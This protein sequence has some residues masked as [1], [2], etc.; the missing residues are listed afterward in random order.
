M[1]Y[2]M[3]REAVAWEIKFSQ[4]S[5][6]DKILGMSSNS[7]ELYAYHLANKR[8]KSIGFDEIFPKNKNPYI[9]LEKQAGSDD[10]TSNRTNNFEGTSITYKQPDIISGWDD[11]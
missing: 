3:F 2:E 11:L 6:G 7:I 8:L 5:I 10:E 9:H 1:V 4:E